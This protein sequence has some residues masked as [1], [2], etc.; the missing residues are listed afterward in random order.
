MIPVLQLL[1]GNSMSVSCEKMVKYV[2]PWIRKELAISLVR[3]YGMPQV[4]VAEILEVT[5]AAISQYL[6]SKRGSDIKIDDENVI[7]KIKMSAETL[8]SGRNSRIS[9]EICSLCKLIRKRGAVPETIAKKAKIDD[10]EDCICDT[11]D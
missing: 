3:D 10:F 7:Q 8:S 2:V 6:S 11:D 9:R 1:W 5:E 4:R